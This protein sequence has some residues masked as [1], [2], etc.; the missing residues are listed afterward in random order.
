MSHQ[1]H[2]H[3]DSLSKGEQLN[4][5]TAYSPGSETETHEKQVSGTERVDG[6]D[7]QIDPDIDTDQ[8]H[9]RPGTGG[10][11]D[12]GDIDVDTDASDFPSPAE[13]SAAAPENAE[14]NA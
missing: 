3:E 12:V 4:K 14:E 6:V 11:D 8:V 7:G 10:P 13:A 5:D 1:M 9:V 2:D